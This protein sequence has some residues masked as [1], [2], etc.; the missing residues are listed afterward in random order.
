MRS[1]VE[2]RFG[3]AVESITNTSAQTN[4]AERS[5]TGTP[6]PRPTIHAVA[7][8][9]LPPKGRL[10]RL[11]RHQP[12]KSRRTTI[13]KPIQPAIIITHH[14]WA[15]SCEAWLAGWTLDWPAFTRAGDGERAASAASG[16]F[17]FPG[18]SQTVRGFAFATDGKSLLM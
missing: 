16:C 18:R 10:G 2:P 7:A 1:C 13:A 17:S 5:T 4:R 12:R 15:I 6:T 9:S 11:R 3:A 8:R 14:R